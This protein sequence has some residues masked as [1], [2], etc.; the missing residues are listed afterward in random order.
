MTIDLHPARV[1]ALV[2]LPLA[3]S[4][5]AALAQ[6]RQDD[7][8]CDPATSA[9]VIGA[10]IGGLVGG[11]IGAEIGGDGENRRVAA[12]A[13][14]VIGAVIGSRIGAEIDRDS[15]EACLLRTR[16]EPRVVTAQHSAAPDSTARWL[17][18]GN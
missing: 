6:P 16:D 5:G 2:V 13:G 4:S 12:L 11:K 8:R 14:S 17:A 15:D 9:K 1:A 18:A 10:V 3:L 7:P